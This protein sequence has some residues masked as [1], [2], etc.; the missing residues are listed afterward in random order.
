M[1]T[2]EDFTRVTNDINGNPRYIILAS[3]IGDAKKQL[4]FKKYRGD[5]RYYVIQSYDIKRTAI[6]CN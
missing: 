2:A 3:L 1:I 4:G 6:M 5:S